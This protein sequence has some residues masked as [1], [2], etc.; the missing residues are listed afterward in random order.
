MRIS[1]THI[2]DL[3]LEADGKAGG[4]GERALLEV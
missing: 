1:F 4:W 2:P 3:Q